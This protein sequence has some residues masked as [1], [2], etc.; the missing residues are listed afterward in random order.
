MGRATEYHSA[1]AFIVSE[2]VVDTTTSPD[3]LAGPIQKDLMPPA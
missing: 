1:C 2:D 3:L